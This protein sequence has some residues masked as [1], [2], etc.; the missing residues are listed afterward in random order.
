MKVKGDNTLISN[1]WDV[2]KI[3]PSVHEEHRISVESLR[4]KCTR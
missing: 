4:S 2:A 1:T 3:K